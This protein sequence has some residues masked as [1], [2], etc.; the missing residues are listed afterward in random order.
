MQKLDGEIKE[1]NEW[2]DGAERKMD[3]IDNQGPNDAV[4][5]VVIFKSRPHPSYTS[6]FMSYVVLENFWDWKK[7]CFYKSYHL[8]FEFGTFVLSE[9]GLWKVIS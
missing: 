9:R 4:L 2:I 8:I 7:S 6:F 3:E 5:K 1:V